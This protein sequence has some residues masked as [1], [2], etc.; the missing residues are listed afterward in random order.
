MMQE[1]VFITAIIPVFN[2]RDTLAEIIARVERVPCIREIVVV[3]DASKDGS[4]DIVREMERAGRIKASYHAKNKGKGAALREGAQLATQPYVAIQDADLEYDPRDFEALAQVAARNNAEVVYGSRF[5]GGKRTGMLW[6]HYLGNR[7]LTMAFNIMY[8]Q[9]IT[10][11]ETCYKVFRTSFLWQIGI[12]NDRFDVDPELTAKIARAGVRI[13]EA[14]V[15]YEG[16]PYL[17]GKKIRPQ[18]ALK[19]LKALWRY[20]VW[21]PEIKN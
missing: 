10:D 2:E 11:M 9:R 14:P 4:A 20:R 1:P 8:G 17:A 6:S 15:S 5:L 3:D 19:A 7:F 12:D 13:Y 21:K 18:D 16:R